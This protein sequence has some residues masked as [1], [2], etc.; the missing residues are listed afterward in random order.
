MQPGISAIVI[1]YNPRELLSRCLSSLSGWVDEL[2]VVD[3]ESEENLASTAKKFHA[4]YQKLPHVEIVEQIRQKCLSLAHHEY[5]LFLDPDE[6]VPPQLATLLQAQ[7]KSNSYDY[8]SIP[9]K[10]LVFGTWLRHSRWW[11]DYQVRLF[12]HGQVKWPTVLHL[13]PEFSGRQ[14]TVLEDEN[15]ALVH[16]NYK[17]LDEWFDK[18]RRYAKL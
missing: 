14:Y 4:V 12:R 5:V 11:P 16:T 3:L 6:V 1:A 9:R 7:V 15:L 2:I 8:F 13:Q 17:D 10:N 18:N